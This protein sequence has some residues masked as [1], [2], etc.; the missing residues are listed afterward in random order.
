MKTIAVAFLLMLAGVAVPTPTACSPSGSLVFTHATVID[1][2]KFADLVILEGKPLD[3]IRNTERIAGV[4]T[5][6]RYLDRR[7]VDRLLSEA[8][9]LSN[10]E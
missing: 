2:R 4:V 3:D 1:A 6:G 5:A 7:G 8:A 9:G 10:K